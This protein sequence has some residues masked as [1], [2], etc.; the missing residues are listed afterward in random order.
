MIDIKRLANTIKRLLDLDELCSWEVA[1]ALVAEQKEF[2]GSCEECESICYDS[3]AREFTCSRGS[4][5][6]IELDFFC[7]DFERKEK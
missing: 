7:A 1:G 6:P 5:D 4:F 2:L 3:D